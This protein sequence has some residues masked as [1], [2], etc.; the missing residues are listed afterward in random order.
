MT[1]PAR[2]RP[3][4]HR[5]VVE[6]SDVQAWLP[7]IAPVATVIAA[8]IAASPVYRQLRLKREEETRL[9]EA[10]R[11][12]VDTRLLGLFVQLMSKAHARGDSTLADGPLQAIITSGSPLAPASPE[13][14][15]RLINAAVVTYPVGASEQEAAMEAVA[16]LGERYPILR[17]P[18]IAGLQSLAKW[19]PSRDRLSVLIDRLRSLDRGQ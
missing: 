13:E 18:A 1:L 17:Q 3:W 12:E 16:A 2:A 6:S 5:L 14:L 10:S 7:V 11:A 4:H 15:T 19:H 9:A 8:S